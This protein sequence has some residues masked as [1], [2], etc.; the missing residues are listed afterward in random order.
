MPMTRFTPRRWARAVGLLAAALPGCLHSADCPRIGEL[1]GPAAARPLDLSLSAEAIPPEPPRPV[2]QT[3]PAAPGLQNRL[4]VPPG[5]PG[6]AV[7]PISLPPLDSANREERARAV[8]KLYPALPALTGDVPIQP[9]PGGRPLDLPALQRIAAEH[10]PALALAAADVEASR[11]NAIQAGLYPNPNFGAQVD[12]AG[13]SDTPGQLGVYFEQVIKTAGKLTL[14]RAIETMNYIN[15]QVA[16]RRAQVDLA[17]KVRGAYFAVLVAQESVRIGVALTRFTDEVY[18]VYVEQVKVAGLAAP[19][20]PLALRAQ[21]AVTRTTLAQA[22]NRYVSAWKQLAI[23]VGRPDLPPTEL[24]G[25][26]DLPVPGFDYPAARDR[27]WAVHTDLV[28]ARNTVI[29][30]KY[31]LQQAKV[32]NV[33]DIQTHIAIQYDTTGDPRRLQT[34]FQIGGAV[35][36]WDRNQGGI[37]N[38]RATLARAEIDVDR[39]RLDLANT[40]TD[41][42]ERYE[43]NR[44]MVRYYREQILPDQVQVYRGLLTRYQQEPDKVALTDI[45]AAQQAV[46]QSLANYLAAET[47]LWQAVVDLAAV[48]QIDDLTAL[49]G[50]LDAACGTPTMAESLTPGPT[51]PAKPAPEAPALLPATHTTPAPPLRRGSE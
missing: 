15:A 41:A 6:A 25:R 34:G 45:F 4:V 29:R 27:I 38:A 36:V 37:L 44:T 23:A 43:T 48:T 22:R 21:A 11:G 32:Q 24:A 12:Q 3:E 40:L 26:A 42:F 13:S 16:L 35:P 28:T 47:L 9:G 19:Y 33:P 20:E 7:P 46:V 30:L 18:R 1:V 49:T 50:P 10:N 51:A 39:A 8:E 31:A 2:A 17:A 14:A 5:L